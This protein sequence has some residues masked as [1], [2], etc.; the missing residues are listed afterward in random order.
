MDAE[1]K[2][3]ERRFA[4]GKVAVEAEARASDGSE[5]PVIRGIA[6]VYY[7]GTEATEFQLWADTYE[8][9]MP[10]SFTRAIAEDDVRGLF[11]HMSSA[12]LGRTRA[13]TMSLKDE[14]KGLAYK[15][16]PPDTQW[17]RDTVTSIQRGDVTGSSFAFLVTDEVWRKET[18]PGTK[19]TK[20]IREILGVE[21]F[22]VGPVTYPAYPTTSAGARAE[23]YALAR[24]SYEAWTAGD[25]AVARHRRSVALAVDVMRRRHELEI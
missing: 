12:V 22:D 10:G 21:L 2:A 8:R 1:S 23:R 6:A 13:K 25:E 16:W 11:N 3:A 5:K 17:G 24:R 20:N 15:I 4:T 9:I 18:P 7:D 14:A 19:K